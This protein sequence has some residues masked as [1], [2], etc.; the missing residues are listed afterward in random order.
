M[1]TY[2]PQSLLDARRYLQG[3]TGLASA[4]LGIVGDTLHGTSGYHVGW[5]R[6]KLGKG[7]GDYSYRES[8]RDHVQADAASALDIGAGW[9]RWRELTL[10]LVAQ[11]AAGAPD[12]RDIREVIYTP[13]GQTVRRWDRLGIR[14]TGDSSHLTHTHISYHRDSEGRDKTA[15]FRRFFEPAQTEDEMNTD[16]NNALAEAWAADA[17]LRDGKPVT[18]AGNYPGGGH[19]LVDQVKALTA[20]VAAVKAATGQPAVDTDA[21]VDQVVERITPLLPSAESV[22]MALIRQLGTGQAPAGT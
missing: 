9:P 7:T 14:S 8:V 17:A 13:D 11:C 4:A 6:L 5:D 3:K 22:A 15:L 18:K 19:W 21:I 1:T 16:Q 12:T 2:A 20:D 10:W